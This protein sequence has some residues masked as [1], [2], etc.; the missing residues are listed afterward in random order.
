MKTLKIS[1]I[2]T[3]VT[4][5]VITLCGMAFASASAEGI[6]PMTAKVVDLDYE[7]DIVTVVNFTGFSFTFEGCEDWD[8]GDC[9]SLIMSDNDTE[10]IYD[11]CILQA[12]YGGWELVDWRE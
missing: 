9:C 10:L 11:D 6:Y 5:L 4:A 7:N 8:V 2:A 12:Y 3:I 1:I